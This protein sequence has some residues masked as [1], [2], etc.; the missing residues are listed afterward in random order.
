MYAAELAR[1]AGVAPGTV[2]YYG[3]IG[4]LHPEQ[5]ASNS[6]YE[7]SRQDLERL[8]FIRAA[9][10]LGFTLTDI[11]AMFR[12]AERGE[13]PCPRARTVIERRLAETERKIA[14]LQ[15]LQNQ[16]KSA[17]DQWTQLPDSQPNGD[18]VCA[19][20]EMVGRD[21]HE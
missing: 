6:Y 3:K 14:E 20:I 18:S 17:I 13:S 21:R 5:N 19:L 10:S 1:R 12:D 7:Y 8:R 16:M 9:K 15:A 4:M 2:R 11:R